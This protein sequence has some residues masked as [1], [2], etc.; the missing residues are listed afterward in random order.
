MLLATVT[1]LPAKS[2]A[3][4]FSASATSAVSPSVAMN[5]RL[6]LVCVRFIVM[7]R[8]FALSMMTAFSCVNVYAAGA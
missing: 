8:T 6:S 5:S 7:M 3:K 4:S 1:E 2:A